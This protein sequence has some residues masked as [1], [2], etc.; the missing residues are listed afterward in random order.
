MNYVFSDGEGEVDNKS[1]VDYVTSVSGGM[2]AARWLQEAPERAVRAFSL[3]SRVHRV[4]FRNASWLP[5]MSD[6]L[7][8]DV[9][10]NP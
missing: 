10:Q 8:F 6:G 5:R 1:G 3:G 4:E 7:D 2:T 9:N